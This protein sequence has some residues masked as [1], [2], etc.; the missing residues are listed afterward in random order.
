MILALY[1][2]LLVTVSLLSRNKSSNTRNGVR[3]AVSFLF[4]LTAQIC[5]KVIANSSGLIYALSSSLFSTVQNI[6]FE[7]EAEWMENMTAGF[8]SQIW[9][10]IFIASGLT[11]ES[12]VC[13]LF[14]KWVSRTAFR[15][16]GVFRK[17]HFVFFGQEDD[18]LRLIEDVKATIKRPCII[19]IPSQ[20]LEPDSEL[21]RVCRI[22]K[23]VYLK[24]LNIRK[25]QYVVLLPNDDLDLL[26][27]DVL[28]QLDADYP[29]GDNIHVTAFLDNDI[30]R[31]H[32][33][34]TEHIDACVLSAE[35]LLV[36][37]FF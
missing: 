28:Y 8:Q 29:D 26:N 17:Q 21:Y 22:E 23:P 27:L 16:R 15:L 32:D 20:P 10:I 1:L 13:A 4:I 37:R 24:R 2:L 18:A 31:W 7:N 5:T 14:G 6:T 36:Y 9:V 33:V 3:V 12:V 34:R 25:E 30:I 35:Q 19:Y 11:V